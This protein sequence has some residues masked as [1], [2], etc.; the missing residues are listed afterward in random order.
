VQEATRKKYRGQTPEKLAGRLLE[1]EKKLV[2]SYLEDIRKALGEEFAKT[3]EPHL[4]ESGS[5]SVN[6]LVTQMKTLLPN[7]DQA[8]LR[9]FDTAKS[10]MIIRYFS[11]LSQ[12]GSNLAGPMTSLLNSV[13]HQW[14]TNRFTIISGF[15]EGFTRMLNGVTEWVNSISQQGV[16]DAMTR[17][18][19]ISSGVEKN[20][21]QA[22]EFA[23]NVFVA[24]LDLS[25]F[26]GLHSEVSEA[27]RMADPRDRAKFSEE[28]VAEMRKSFN[29]FQED[30]SNIGKAI[31]SFTSKIPEFTS[32]MA[33][34]VNS[35][36]DLV[37]TMNYFAKRIPFGP[38][39]DVE[40]RAEIEKRA[41][42]VYWALDTTRRM[43]NSS[44]SLISI[45]E[46]ELQKLLEDQG[47]TGRTLPTDPSHTKRELNSE[48]ARKAVEK[49]HR[50][51]MTEQAVA[52][53]KEAEKAAEKFNSNVSLKGLAEDAAVIGQRIGSSAAAALNSQVR[54]NFSLNA[55][56]FGLPLGTTAPAS[57]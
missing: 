53:T 28:R 55:P 14:D 20:F 11:A 26:F 48:I 34:M 41:R 13:S 9:Q 27:E 56:Y 24:I 16:Q 29:Q 33:V 2:A 4:K 1:V 3:I 54:L 19:A 38:K 23:R 17:F 57:P 25:K 7:I 15:T 44:K 8:A 50:E 52:Q 46:R 37:D 45:L 18:V 22:M 30:M 32:A 5:K 51:L 21:T 31:S 35:L 43:P 39:T 47:T 12:L 10:G 36:S 6:A 42:D 49:L 40:K